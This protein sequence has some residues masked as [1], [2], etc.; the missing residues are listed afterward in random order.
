MPHLAFVAFEPLLLVCRQEYWMAIGHASHLEDQLC[1]SH[2]E[3]E[4]GLREWKE[5]LRPEI[6]CQAQVAEA[7]AWQCQK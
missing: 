4:S 7:R 5:L 6:S 3:T 1:S 2:E